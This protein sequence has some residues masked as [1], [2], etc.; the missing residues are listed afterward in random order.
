[1]HFEINGEKS[2]TDKGNDMMR[3][4]RLLHASTILLAMAGS[5]AIAAPAAFASELVIAAPAD[6]E[7]ANLDYQVDPYSQDILFDSFFT[8]PLIIVA[9][10]GSLKPGL[11][12]EW[13]ASADSKEF[14]LKLRPG[15]KFQDGT[16]FNAEAVKYNFARIKA[17]ETAS[18][19]LANNIG[20]LKSV[21]VVDDLTVKFKYDVPK[22]NFFSIAVTVPI[23]SPTAAKASTPQ[24]F[25]KKLVGT[26]QFKL[27]EWKRND[28]FSMVKWDGYS[29]ANSVQEHKGPALVDKV[30]VKFI[31]EPSVL[32]SMVANGEAD[33]GYSIPALSA[34]QYRNASDAS[35]LTKD[36]NGTGLS[37]TMNTAKPPLD[38]KDVRQAL[39]YGHDM[40]AVND[41]VYDG[42]YS[43]ADGPLNNNHTC[44]WPGATTA[45]PHDVAKA[46][47]LLDKA[48]WMDDGSGVRKAKGVKGVSDGTPLT[49][50][51][52]ILHHQEIG[53]AV[54]AQLKQI[55][56]DL[57]IEKVPGTVQLDRV[58]RRDFDLMYERLRSSDPQILTDIYNPANDK[59]GGWFWSGF[60]NDELTK[61]VLDVS[62]NPDATA[63]CDSA[64]KAQQ[65]IMENAV[66]FP[67]LNEP[68]FV[69]V[70]KSVKGF[71]MGAEG[72]FFFLNDVSKN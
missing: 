6:I 72:T 47:S 40:G 23:W 2:P 52:T 48:G 21:E 28:H 9:P 35:L 26:G 25:D 29:G 15:V 17:P 22:V 34:D 37:M 59:P 65:L 51:W 32:G 18:A 5:A 41:L 14:T 71:K 7:P 10:D 63:R 20:P 44:F 11:A 33:I 67:T 8:D 62:N 54:Q 1:V 4:T 38:N 45:Y 57:K 68:V 66:V 30:T 56:V 50:R 39:M 64:K 43:R 36:Q 19:L 12:T 53:E 42:L 24:D 27:V 58:Q 55:G 60:K 16:P 13:S 31:G 61:L 49:I 3:Y 69:A 46:K 70:S